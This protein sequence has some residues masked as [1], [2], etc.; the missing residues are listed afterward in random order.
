MQAEVRVACRL[1]PLNAREDASCLAYSDQS[2]LTIGTQHFSFDPVFPPD[3]PQHIVHDCIA[4][5]LVS[6]L[7]QGFNVSILTYGQT[8]SGKT[9][10][11]TGTEEQPGLIPRV[12]ETL[13]AAIREAEK[14]LE[15]SLKV[16]YLDLYCERLRDLLEFSNESLYIRE[17]RQ[18]GVYVSGLSEAYIASAADL[19][20]LVSQGFR[21]RCIA[22][23]HMSECSSRS[24]SLLLLT[25]THTARPDLVAKTGKM[26][27]VDLAGSERIAKTGATGQIFKEAQ[28][29]NRSLSV[30]SMIICTLTDEKSSHVPYRDSKLTRLLQDSLGG[31][32]YTALILTCSPASCNEEET[33]RTLRLGT[34][35]KLVQNRPQIN[36]EL[37]AS[38]LKLRLARAE[39]EIK[40]RNDAIR[41]LRSQLTDL[42]VASPEDS[43]GQWHFAGIEEEVRK[44]MAHMREAI[45]ELKRENEAV[46]G[47]S[48]T[49][50][51]DGQ[52][53]VATAQDCSH[54][55]EETVPCNAQL[56]AENA[57]LKE[58]I[59]SLLSA[60]QASARPEAETPLWRVKKRV[61]PGTE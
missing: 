35:A 58:Q 20:M 11:L 22:Q 41:Q 48:K 32:A 60:L 26:W 30:L 12:G 34:R 50:C 47:K 27:L 18:R 24:H 9:Y 61:L 2:R 44:E 40:G 33:I 16:S 38:E 29:I 7:L 17:D 21:N 55:E 59:R 57:A 42:G 49:C 15:F 46:R 56:M 8:G 54:T 37:T 51:V 25:V 45:E 39:A 53:Q 3:T 43:Q 1:R 28:N 14:G 5:P 52:K 10:T 19:R 6:S 4:K 31:N 23:T 13:F 36:E